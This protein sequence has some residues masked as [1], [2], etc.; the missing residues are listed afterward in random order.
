[1]AEEE[2][3]LNRTIFPSTYPW[4]VRIQKLELGRSQEKGASG[5]K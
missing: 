1:M 4:A 5:Y 2:A 3:A